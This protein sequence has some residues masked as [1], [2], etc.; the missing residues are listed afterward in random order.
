MARPNQDNDLEEPDSH[1]KRSKIRK[2]GLLNE[3]ATR[4]DSAQKTSYPYVNQGY[5][6]ENC[7]R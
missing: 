3:V 1:L 6:V 4:Q 2:A 7:L 5:S